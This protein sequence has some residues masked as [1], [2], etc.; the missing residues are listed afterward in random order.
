MHFLSKS[1][2]PLAF[3]LLFVCAALLP[4]IKNAAADKESAPYELSVQA[5]Q[6]SD[7][8]VEVSLA[9]KVIDDNYSAPAEAKKI[10]ITS[11]S[12]KTTYK[13]VNLTANSDLTKSAATLSYEN[14]KDANQIDVTVKI[15]NREEKVNVTLKSEANIYLLPDL[16]ID[17]YALED[18]IIE[19]QKTTVTAIISNLNYDHEAEADV[20]LKEGDV[21]LDKDKVSLKPDSTD[22]DTVTLNTIFET[23]G[24]HDLTISI[25]NTDTENDYD[26]SNNTIS[27]TVEVNSVTGHLALNN[28][29]NYV[30][31]INALPSITLEITEDEWNNQLLLYDQNPRHEQESTANFTFDKKGV[32]EQ[33]KE[34]GFRIRGDADNRTR[35]EGTEGEMHNSESPDWHMANFKINFTKADDN[36][37]FYDLRE[38]NLDCFKDDESYAREIYC[39]DLLKKFGV[40][41]SPFSSYVR[42]Y[43]KIDADETPAYYGV[44][45]M[46]EGID[47]EYLKDRFGSN[48]DGY[49]WKN[50]FGAD[51]TDYNLDT[52]TIGVEDV[53]L[54]EEA[55]YRPLYDLKTNK[56]DIDNAKEQLVQFIENLNSKTGEDFEEWIQSAMDVDLFLKTCA[57]NTLVGS[58][59]DYWVYSN[60][61]YLYFDENDRAFFIPY[62]FNDTLGIS[63]YL[64]NTGTQDV[65]KWGAMNNSRPLIYKILSVSQFRDQYKAYIQELLNEEND[66]FDFDHS[67][68]S[69]NTWQAMIAD[70]I[71]NDTGEMMEISDQPPDWSNAVFY[72]LLTGDD[73]GKEPE[74]N[75]FKTRT[76]F[77]KEHIADDAG[78]TSDTDPI[79]AELYLVGDFSDWEAV[80][81]FKF[82][83]INNTYTVDAN[84]S[85]FA[86]T[87]K[88]VDE[89]W[90]EKTH[91]GASVNNSS[92]TLGEPIRVYSRF[93][94]PALSNITLEIDTPGTYRF[95]FDVTDSENP[96]LLVTRIE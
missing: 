48:D 22:T 17:S 81:E 3:I 1:K 69:I 39:Y 4:S 65:M 85:V 75:W 28:D 89:S 49:L 14:K 45:K 83:R 93:S 30:F 86:Y 76:T 63:Y 71:E 80:E 35:P 78:W 20:Y 90:Y 67:V 10:T 41:T 54:V 64:D 7:N 19:N 96:T 50:T 2:N 23:E 68:D 31:D 42:L 18:E 57:V 25:E 15:K 24:S 13:N 8:R 11:S 37:R 52:D 40:W 88:I 60:N 95:E 36:Q 44:Y 53:S 92:V 66:Y 47:K 74:A 91:F 34:I 55:S 56:S 62:N 87:F 94:D 46:I 26:S 27:F 12:G 9:I 73:S 58:W 16:K 32:S 79:T 29:L 61:Y 51:L 33:V 72:R 77:A 6:D 70:Y 38:I 84:L 43:I 59:D 5:L 82:N 21:V